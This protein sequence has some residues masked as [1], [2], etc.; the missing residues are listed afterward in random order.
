MQF[1]K[2]HNFGFGC[3]TWACSREGRG[4]RARGYDFAHQFF[5]AV[6]I[7]GFVLLAPRAPH[8]VQLT[9]GRVVL[10]IQ[11]GPVLCVHEFCQS[12]DARVANHVAA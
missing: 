12:E 1:C 7:L 4:R 8:R 10:A 11:H 6:S 9:S 3:K 2:L 5:A